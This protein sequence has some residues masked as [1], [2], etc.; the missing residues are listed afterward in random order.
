MKDIFEQNSVRQR[1][2]LLSAEPVAMTSTAQSQQAP[3]D[4][5]RFDVTLEFRREAE[6]MIHYLLTQSSLPALLIHSEWMPVGEPFD[7]PNESFYRELASPSG[8]VVHKTSY[9]DEGGIRHLLF[10]GRNA[11]TTEEQYMTSVAAK[12]RTTESA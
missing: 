12:V 6:G 3:N 9:P 1:D 11:E 2:Q 7:F 10:L 5:W 8:C 4:D